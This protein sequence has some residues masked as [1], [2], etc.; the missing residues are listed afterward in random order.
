MTRCPSREGNGHPFPYEDET[1]AR[2]PEHGVTLLWHGEPIT[3][4]D[5]APEASPDE[6]EE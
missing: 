2:C 3:A 5:L 6:S 1:T 4:D